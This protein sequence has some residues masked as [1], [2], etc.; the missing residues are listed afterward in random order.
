[1][2]AMFAEQAGAY[3]AGKAQSAGRNA[4]RA[5]GQAKIVP[6]DRAYQPVLLAEFL[7]AV[8]IIA[9][10]PVI[11]GGSDIA[12]AKGSMSPYDTGD[13][14]QLVAAGGVFFVLALASS[15]NSGRL[16]AWL[17]GLILIAIAF[18][19]VANGGVSAVF[20]FAKPGKGV[21]GAGDT[22]GGAV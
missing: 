2:T 4:A 17:G 16:S 5:A 19:K 14:R 13:L 11:T 8:A 21:A 1:M 7:A 20:N 15:G 3:A 9:L 22:A 18:G 10:P 12:K 6:G